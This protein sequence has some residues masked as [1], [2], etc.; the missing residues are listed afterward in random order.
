MRFSN[1][2]YDCS[3]IGYDSIVDEIVGDAIMLGIDVESEAMSGLISKIVGAIKKRVK[4]KREKKQS[5]AGT[6]PNYQLT[7]PQGVAS[8]GPTGLTWTQPTIQ[9]QS[10]D[11]LK[12]PLVLAGLIGIPLLLILLS[13]RS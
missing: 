4:E 1:D 9:T 7:T 5:S 10:T 13:K 3:P 2:D 6:I 8:I 12:N 11:M